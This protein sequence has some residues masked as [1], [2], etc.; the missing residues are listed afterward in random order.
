MSESQFRDSIPSIKDI[1]RR[2]VHLALMDVEGNQ[3][4]KQGTSDDGHDVITWSNGGTQFLIDV[5]ANQLYEW[6]GHT[7]ATSD[8]SRLMRFVVNHQLHKRLSDGGYGALIERLD[9]AVTTLEREKSRK[10][11]KR[12]NPRKK[13]EAQ[14]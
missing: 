10:V 2:V 3:F 8:I 9:K 7:I 5:D 1:D 11:A 4:I 13:K 14:P 6:D 12:A